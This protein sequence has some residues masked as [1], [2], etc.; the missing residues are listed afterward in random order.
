MSDVEKL[1]TKTRDLLHLTGSS[2]SWDAGGLDDSRSLAP[3]SS[4]EREGIEVIAE[5]VRNK[6]EVTK[7]PGHLVIELHELSDASER[8]HVALINRK[9]IAN[10]NIEVKLLNAESKIKL[11]EGNFPQARIV[12]S[13]LREKLSFSCP[14]GS[15]TTRSNSVCLDE[16]HNRTCLP[17]LARTHEMEELC[18]HQSCSNQRGHS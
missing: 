1:V 9:I 14:T 15:T 8:A 12:C 10:G 16:F 11:Y 7:E 2:A 13:S 3:A 4:P 5:K 18:R 17:D 6:N